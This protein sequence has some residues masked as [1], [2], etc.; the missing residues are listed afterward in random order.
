MNYAFSENGF[1]ALYRDFKNFNA[2]TTILAVIIS[3][4]YGL[5][6]YRTYRKE[7]SSM[8]GGNPFKMTNHCH[9]KNV[10]FPNFFFVSGGE[11][12][13]SSIVCERE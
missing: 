4:S 10:I 2:P 13:L 9:L 11:L 5:T 8:R 3:T 7:K 6:S 12:F 1:D